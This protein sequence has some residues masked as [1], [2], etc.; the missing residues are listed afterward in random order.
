MRDKIKFIY[1]KGLVHIM[2][3]GLL[4]KVFTF[5]G[6]VFV[7]RFLTKREYGIFGYA[8]NIMT[9]FLILNGMGIIYGC[10]NS[11]Q[12]R[13]LKRKKRPTIGFR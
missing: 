9:F 4:N 10:F 2:G 8:D 13:G 1:Q 7:V 11:V 6:N 12:N 5:I 3:S